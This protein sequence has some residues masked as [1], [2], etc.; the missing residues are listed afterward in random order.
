MS[1]AHALSLAAV[2]LMLKGP[3]DDAQKSIVNISSMMGRASGRGYL[4]YGTAKAALAHWARLAARDLAP[5]IR[6]NGIFVGSVM[7]SALEFVA[8][9]PE[10]KQQMEDK[11]PLGRVGEAEDI[12]AAAIY[13]SSRA[14]QYVTGKMLEVDGGIQEPN[15]DLN[16]PDVR[17]R[18]AQVSPTSD[19]AH[20]IS[21]DSGEHWSAEGA[22]PVAPGI[23]RIPLPLPMDGLKAVNVYAIE[24]DDGLTLIDGGWA[25]EVARDL[26]EKCLRDVGYGFG[27]IRRFLVTHIHRDHYTMAAVLGKEFGADVALGRGEEPGLDLLNDLANLTENP[28]VRALL[29]AG[30]ADVADEWV[31][32]DERREMPD[33]AWWAYPDTWLDGDL[34][35]AVGAAHDRRRTHS[36]A[37]ARALRLRRP[38]RRAALRRRPRAADDHAVDRLHD[39]AGRAPARR[40]HG[41]ADQGARPARP[42]DPARPRPGRAVLAHP[43]RRAA[44]P[45]RGP[46]GA[47]AWR[48][49]SSGPATSQ[50]VAR[51]L[52]WTR[53]QRAYADLDVFNR[54]MATMETKAH[55]ELLV[56]RGRRASRCVTR[57]TACWCS[58]L[59]SAR[60]STGFMH[61][62]S[63]SFRAM[64][65]I[66][67]STSELRRPPHRHVRDPVLQE[68]RPGGLEPERLVP[69]RQRRLGVEHHVAGPALD[70]RPLHQA[71]RPDPARASTGATT[72][73]PI[74]HRSRSSR[75]RA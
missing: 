27:D 36:G 46:A 25:I 10:M 68:L 57:T 21:P 75:T 37:H 51:Q 44:R 74:R 16:L 69:G 23:H 30:A 52:P 3:A 63:G 14:G 33:P 18:L 29:T 4:A 28:F 66:H 38:R 42:A 11:T 31:R 47:V 32:D 5:R 50:D 65:A 67:W 45:P 62:G 1:T 40:L 12:A 7:T 58:R 55:L 8:G 17:P 64:C 41:V 13:L 24:T 43:R 9:V 39:A 73:R 2:P 59:R 71:R 26:L 6:V 54:G 22:W 61:S 48:R 72:T 15:L 70:Q 60:L 20:A 19:T 53:H 56:A 35:I 34:E 49:S